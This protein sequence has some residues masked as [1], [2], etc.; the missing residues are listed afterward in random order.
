VDFINAFLFTF[1]LFTTP[2]DFFVL[3]KKRYL[4]VKKNKDKHPKNGTIFTIVSLRIIV[5]PLLSSRL[6][7][8]SLFTLLSS[9]SLSKKFEQIL[10][11]WI[12]SPRAAGDFYYKDG[13]FYKNVIYRLNFSHT[14]SSKNSWEFFQMRARPQKSQQEKYYGR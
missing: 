8:P 11:K 3:L 7:S 14:C 9:F 5:C 10:S 2:Q 1:H 4:E 12:K 6:F 13:S